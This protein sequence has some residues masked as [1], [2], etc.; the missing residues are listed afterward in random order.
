MKKHMK[1]GLITLGCYSL[2]VTLTS[3][4]KIWLDSMLDVGG[5]GKLLNPVL[6]VSGFWD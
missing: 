2:V 1:C 6:L 3:C 4:I 5:I